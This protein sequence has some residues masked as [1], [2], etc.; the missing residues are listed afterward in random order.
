[1]L[2]DILYRNKQEAKVKIGYTDKNIPHRLAAVQCHCPFE[3]DMLCKLEGM[4]DTEKYIQ[5]QFKHL[6]IRG[7]WYRIEPDLQSFI[8]NPTQPPITETFVPIERM[9][10]DDCPII[11]ELYKKGYSIR[12]ICDDVPY[13]VSQ[14]RRYITK[15]KL[16]SKYASVRHKKTKSGWT[17]SDRKY[18][19]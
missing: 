15:H 16:H 8:D 14:V 10:D 5:N 7:E 6:H 19:Y 3:V 4:R 1:M 18:N 11:E 13:S 12:K 2:Y 9:K 17:R